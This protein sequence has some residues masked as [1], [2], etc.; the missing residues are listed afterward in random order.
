MD[1][2]AADSAIVMPQSFNLPGE[3]L[4][5]IINLF[6]PVFIIIAYRQLFILKAQAGWL[7]I[8]TFAIIDSIYKLVLA[9]RMF[10]IMRRATSMR[11]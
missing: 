2:C 5:I 8:Y 7:N 1:V 3:F 9:R 4:Q 6:T 10:H 11:K